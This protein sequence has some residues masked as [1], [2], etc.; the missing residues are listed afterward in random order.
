MSNE[1]N[2][3]AIEPILRPTR[4]SGTFAKDEKYRGATPGI[5]STDWQV[6]FPVKTQR[7]VYR[8]KFLQALQQIITKGE[9]LLAVDTDCK[10]LFKILFSKDWIVYAKRPLEPNSMYLRVLNLKRKAWKLKELL[11]E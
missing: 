2:E 6:L 8:A 11:S 3:I 10:K 4:P 5:I 1:K 7:I 9:V